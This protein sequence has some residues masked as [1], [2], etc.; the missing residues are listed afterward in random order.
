MCVCERDIVC[1]CVH[2][3]DI[4]CACMRVCVCVFAH[5]S[6]Y[7]DHSQTFTK[8]FNTSKRIAVPQLG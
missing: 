6:V 4:V 5:S 1:A 8:L 7:I 2:E 3:R